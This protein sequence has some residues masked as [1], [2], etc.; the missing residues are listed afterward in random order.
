MP[1]R[2]LGEVRKNTASHSGEKRV[3]V[4]YIQKYG[5]VKRRQL[6]GTGMAS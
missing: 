4:L 2:G 6:F 5:A 1:H 3:L